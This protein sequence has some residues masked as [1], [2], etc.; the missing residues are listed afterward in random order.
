[1]F[2]QKNS[3]NSSVNQ[4]NPTFPNK[5][6][7]NHRVSAIIFNQDKLLLIYRLKT[8]QEYYALPGGGVETGELPKEAIIREIKEELGIG[9]DSLTE[10]HHQKTPVRQD[11][12]YTCFTR[13]LNISVTGPEKNHLQDQ[14]N[15]FNP[16]W[17]TKGSI[18]KI[19][20]FP[21]P[22][23]ELLGKQW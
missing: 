17:V 13:D 14:N 20:V 5:V 10:I 3:I 16:V 8:G 19:P 15:L 23:E 22:A 21:K 9:I 12:F 2:F 18:Q 11:T 7:T 6:R 1:M 4:L